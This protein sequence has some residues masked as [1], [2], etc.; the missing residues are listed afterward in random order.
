M[1]K[2][3]FTVINAKGRDYSALNHCTTLNLVEDGVYVY[4]KL[5]I[6]SLSHFAVNDSGNRVVVSDATKFAVA[7]KYFVYNG[8]IYYSEVDSPVKVDTS[9]FNIVQDIREV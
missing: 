7:N 1:V 6:P 4:H 2:Q 3:K 8:D 9:K 5:I